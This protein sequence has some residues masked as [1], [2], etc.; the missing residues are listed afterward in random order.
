MVAFIHRNDFIGL[1]VKS[2]QSNYL[3]QGVMNILGNKG[4]LMLQ[5]TLYQ[6]SFSFINVHLSSGANKAGSRADMMGAALKN[7]SL[8]KTIDKFEP[9]AVADFNIILGD[10]NSRFKSTFTKHIDQIDESYIMIPVLDE[11]Y[12]QRN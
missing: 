1:K 3:T 12:E 9:D 6:K 2:V 10:L 7:I 11:L 4:G 8:S 5:F